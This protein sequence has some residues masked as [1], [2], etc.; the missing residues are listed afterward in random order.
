MCINSWFYTQNI[1]NKNKI[2]AEIKKKLIIDSIENERCLFCKQEQVNIC[3]YCFFSLA[4][5]VIKGFNFKSLKNF[6]EVFNYKIM[7][8]GLT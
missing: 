8:F 3:T 2:N 6:D 5:K 1:G 7:D 4:K